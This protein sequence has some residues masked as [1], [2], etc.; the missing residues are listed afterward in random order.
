MTTAT[1]LDHI[2]PEPTPS[3]PSPPAPVP[4]PDVVPV[5]DPVSPQQPEPVREPPDSAPPIATKHSIRR[6]I[7]GGSN[8]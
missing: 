8:L 5:R 4:G 7:A 2:T 3:P 6:V 1:R